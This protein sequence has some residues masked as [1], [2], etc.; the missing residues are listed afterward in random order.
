MLTDR[1]SMSENRR[2]QKCGC[3]AFL[4]VCPRSEHAKVS[5]WQSTPSTPSMNTITYIWGGFQTSIEC[6]ARGLAIVEVADVWQAAL[7]KTGA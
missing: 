2:K 5:Y 7:V 1:M 3:L 4:G 6:L